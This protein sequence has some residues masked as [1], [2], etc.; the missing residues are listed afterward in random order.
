MI[1]SVVYELLAN[2]IRFRNYSCLAF[3]VLVKIMKLTYFRFHF[4]KKSSVL[5][6]AF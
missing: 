4:Y 5:L 6:L 2:N 3:G 1:D